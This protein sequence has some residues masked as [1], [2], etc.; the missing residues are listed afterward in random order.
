MCAERHTARESAVKFFLS[1]SA[2]LDEAKLYQDRENKPLGRFLPEV[3][4]IINC[5]VE[6]YTDAHG[7]PLPPCIVMEKGES[8]D[9]WAARG[10]DGVDS[11]TGLQVRS[12]ISVF[13][14]LCFK[15]IAVRMWHVSL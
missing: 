11:V 2:F 15:F 12:H 13:C 8:L 10:G 7:V 3:H 4:R 1:N 14:V 9:H 6:G 5:P